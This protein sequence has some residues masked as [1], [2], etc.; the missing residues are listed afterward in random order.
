MTRA[1]T[2]RPRRL[3]AAAFLGL[4]ALGLGACSKPL[5]APTDERTPFDRY[6]TVRN[7]YA[8]QYVENEFGRIRPN[9][10]GRLAPR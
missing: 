3:G 7:E 6:D 10:R 5:L 2:S 1:G 8:K 9:L 4:A